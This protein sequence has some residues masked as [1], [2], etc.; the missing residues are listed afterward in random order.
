MQCA[1]QLFQLALGVPV[2]VIF[3]R[4]VMVMR[5]GMCDRMRMR[6]TVVRM[7]E[8]MRM[9]MDVIPYQRIHHEQHRSEDHDGKRDKVRPDRPQMRIC[10]CRNA[11]P[12]SYA[13]PTVSPGLQQLLWM[14][15]YPFLFNR[16]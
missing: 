11:R 2:S 4:D 8:R 13:F 9:N 14:D 16:I 6:Q 1:R 5:M 3:I 10:S 7:G 12:S 15:L